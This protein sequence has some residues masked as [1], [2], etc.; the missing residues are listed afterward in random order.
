MAD[1]VVRSLRL[2]VDFFSSLPMPGAG[3]GGTIGFSTSPDPP[4]ARAAATAAPLLAIVRGAALLGLTL[5]L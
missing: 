2:L 5:P 1:L 3:G 4:A